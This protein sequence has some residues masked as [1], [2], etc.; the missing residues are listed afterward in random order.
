MVIFSFIGTYFSEQRP[1]ELFKA[2]RLD[3]RPKKA[4]RPTNLKRSQI[5]EI[6]PKKANLATLTLDTRLFIV[7]FR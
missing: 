7:W 2:N 1:N 6:W 5:F 4:R 3:L